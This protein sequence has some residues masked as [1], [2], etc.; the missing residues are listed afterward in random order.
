MRLPVT[1]FLA[2]RVEPFANSAVLSRYQAGTHGRCAWIGTIGSTPIKQ[3][4]DSLVFLT[5]TFIGTVAGEGLVRTMAMAWLVKSSYEALA[6]PFTS[7][8]V[9]ALSESKGSTR[10]TTG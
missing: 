8:E 1:S 4:F 2:Y 10:T 6:T 7:L 3:R 5:G 9:N